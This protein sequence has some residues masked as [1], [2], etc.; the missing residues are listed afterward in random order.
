MA[1]NKHCKRN[2]HHWQWWV[3]PKDNGEIRTFEMS[4]IARTEMVCDWLG[5]QKA[6]KVTTGLSAWYAERE[7]GMLLGPKTKAWLKKELKGI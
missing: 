7:V 2:D 6:L 5:V 4:E 3:Q 1:W